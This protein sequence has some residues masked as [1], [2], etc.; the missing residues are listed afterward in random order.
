MTIRVIDEN[1]AIIVMRVLI[2]NGF[3]VTAQRVLWDGLEETIIEFR[4][5]DFCPWQE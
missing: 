5:A 2:N 3:E 4:K 1:E